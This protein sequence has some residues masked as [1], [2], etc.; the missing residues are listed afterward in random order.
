MRSRVSAAIIPRISAARRDARSRPDGPA[1]RTLAR[2]RQRLDRL[3]LGQGQAVLEVVRLLRDLVG[4][5]H[6]LRLER[7][8]RLEPQ[9][10]AEVERERERDASRPC[11]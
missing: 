3:F 6:E 1:A 10:L 2:D 9:T 8:A 7:A 5:V 4:P 11:A